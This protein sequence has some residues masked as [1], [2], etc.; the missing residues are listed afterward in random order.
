MRIHLRTERKAVASVILLVSCWIV[1]SAVPLAH[2]PTA[3]LSS[4]KTSTPSAAVVEQD[5]DKPASELNH[6]LAGYA[7]IAI[8]VLAIAGH[9]SRRLRLLRFI[10]PFLFVMA[11]L[12]L[13]AWS[14]DEIWPRG[15]LS[16]LW[17][18]H[19]DRE[20]GQHK[21]YAVLLIAM[22][23]IE[24]LRGRATL[25]R[26]SQTCAFP[27]VALL[28]IVLL[29]F[30]D[31]T[32]GSG[33][34]FPEAAKYMVSE[35]VAGAMKDGVLAPTAPMSPTLAMYHREMQSDA[36]PVELP[37]P[38]QK[39]SEHA[40]MEM[41]ERGSGH[42]HR[43]T[44]AMLKVEHQHLWFALVGAAIVLFKLISDSN[45]WSRSFVPYLWPSCITVLGMLLVLYTE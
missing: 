18:V 42:Q 21:I 39:G 41:Q 27:L 26:F 34:T 11:G 36:P 13:A 7:L 5:P 16:W 38:Q 19:H 30:H 24:Y 44:A 10:W 31:H 33:V 40:G 9:S 32:A 28:G 17:L 6:H 12:F 4:T 29:L 45:L 14:D 22:G 25:S 23:I 3:A 1:A 20:A 43:M 15:T 35:P 2:Q 37:P 8:G